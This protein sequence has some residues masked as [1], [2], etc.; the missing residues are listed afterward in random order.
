MYVGT[1]KK[2]EEQRIVCA[3]IPQSYVR[4]FSFSREGSQKK[5][6]DLKEGDEEE[7][8]IVDWLLVV[9]VG[10]NK[11]KERIVLF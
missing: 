9:V 4:Y 7:K 6:D 10:W 8:E 1:K 3:K 11:K 2:Q 5:K